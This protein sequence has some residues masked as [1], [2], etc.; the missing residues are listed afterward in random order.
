MTDLR[1]TGSILVLKNHHQT[2]C[3]FGSK[4]KRFAWL[5]TTQ[6]SEVGIFTC[7]T[8]G[9]PQR[10]SETWLPSFLLCDT[11]LTRALTNTSPQK[12]VYKIQREETTRENRGKVNSS[13][14]RRSGWG[15]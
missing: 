5:Y 9:T 14:L 1:Q 3:S 15:S 2:S 8:M 12:R 4:Y 11:E 10:A 13:G 7:A 6:L